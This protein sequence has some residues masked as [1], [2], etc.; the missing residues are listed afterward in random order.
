DSVLGSSGTIRTISEVLVAQGWCETGITPRGLQRLRDKL[1]EAGHWEQL[2]LDELSERR[3]PVFAGGVAILYAVVEAMKLKQIQISEGALREGII[4]ELI[5]RRQNVDI[6]KATVSD[7][8]KH[9]GVDQQQAAKVIS[10]A[11]TLFQQT[12]E[13]WQ[14]QD[15]HRDI[16]LW[17]AE[18]HEIGLA[19][20]HVQYHRHGAYL[21]SHSNM[22]GFS[23]QEQQGLAVLVSSH[24][25][26]YP[27][28]EFDD[29]MLDEK[30]VLK[31]LGILLRLAYVLNRSRSNT[32]TPKIKV[33]VDGDKLDLKFSGGWFSSDWLDKHPLTQAD[34]QA[35]VEYLTAADFTLT[36][37]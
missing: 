27:L 18:L 2:S 37:G 33:T 32:T 36:F 23:R 28:Q 29:L 31:R 34:L 35:E 15:Q 22:P 4:Y 14:L 17:A 1:V 10:T 5:G 11:D 20:A 9:Y 30:D 19:I 25:R 21:L 16:L 8:A 13:H 24:R 7:M 6:R 12:K 3:K 26:K